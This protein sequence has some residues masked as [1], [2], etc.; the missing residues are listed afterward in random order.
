MF[1][2]G[3][4][5][6]DALIEIEHPDGSV[7]ARSIEVTTGQ[8]SVAQVSAKRDAGFRLY[9]FPV[10]SWRSSKNRKAGGPPADWQEF[11]LS[12]GR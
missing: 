3:V 2:S 7:S 5:L 9:S 1:D 10:P 11:P 8:Y 6:P 12:W 4:P